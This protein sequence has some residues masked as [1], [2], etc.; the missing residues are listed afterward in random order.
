MDLY[1]ALKSGTCAEE[2]SNK[3]NEELKDAMKRVKEE[4]EAEAAEKKKTEDLKK[5]E[6][7]KKLK[8]EEDLA[9]AR[10]Y[11]AEDLLTY[12]D[13]LFGGELED[14]AIT[15]DEIVE[16]LKDCEKNIN[17]FI[18]ISKG[19]GS[20]LKTGAAQEKKEIGK[21]SSVKIKYDGDWDQIIKDFINTL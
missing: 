11:L 7:L 17:S 19:L 9:D 6:E 2:L 13:V 12:I 14:D 21:N 16:A 3:F 1:E 18:A 15:F 10:D 4:K 8:Y 20:L 5:I